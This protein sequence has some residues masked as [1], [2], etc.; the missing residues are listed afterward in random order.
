MS[1]P[2]R[3]IKP[4]LLKDVDLLLARAVQEIQALREVNK[5]QREKLKI[6]EDMI[7]LFKT[8]DFRNRDG[9]GQQSFDVVQ[10]MSKKVLQ[11][12]QYTEGVKQ[13]AS[14]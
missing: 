4:D 12:H 2:I 9:L 1:G 6:Y 3:E 5:T 14:K 7:A 8:E 10:E 13:D 11:I